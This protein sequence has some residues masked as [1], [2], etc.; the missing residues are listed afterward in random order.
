LIKN[1]TYNTVISA[2]LL[3]LYVFI[4]TPVQLWHHH[5]HEPNSA[6]NK[7][8]TNATTITIKETGQSGETYCQICS[9]HYSIYN[10]DAVPVFE[11]FTYPIHSKEGYYALAVLLAPYF[12]STNKGPPA[13]T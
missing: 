6:A 4:A 12:N 13:L 3:T 10:N 1:Q 8:A 9:H 7:S 11:I 2:L 5:S